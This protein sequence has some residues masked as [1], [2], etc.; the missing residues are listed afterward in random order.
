MH[1]GIAAERITVIH[2]GVTLP[3]SLPARLVTAQGFPYILF[4]GTKQAHKN[5]PRLIE[6]FALLKRRDG[7]PHRLILVGRPGSGSAAITAALARWQ[8]HEDVWQEEHVDPQRLQSWF[9]H[10]DLFV[11]PSL[12]EGFGLPP[13][14]AMAHGTPVACADV[15]ALPEVVGEVALRFDPL[16]VSSLYAALQR[17]LADEKWRAQARAAGRQRAAEFSWQRAAQEFLRLL[18]TQQ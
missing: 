3:Q 12:Y 4:V 5:I 7:V 9:A 16:E 6:A 1:L 17:G 13:L 8:L 18:S 10:A 14:E 2:E 15:A 11:F